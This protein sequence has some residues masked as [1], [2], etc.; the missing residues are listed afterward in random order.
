MELDPQVMAELEKLNAEQADEI[1]KL[2]Q[3]L[4]A[5]NTEL[6]KA[7]IDASVSEQNARMEKAARGEETARR[8]E[9]E[10]RLN[11]YL[12]AH[13]KMTAMFSSVQF[14]DHRTLIYAVA[15]QLWSRGMKRAIVSGC[16][17][18]VRLSGEV[19][20]RCGESEHQQ[21]Q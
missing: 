21:S 7:N 18:K 15:M 11:K 4:H 3:Q 9:A 19:R 2:K 8:E 14:T 20:S 6:L 17:A 10:A 12:D 16:D 5:Q 1:K 13:K